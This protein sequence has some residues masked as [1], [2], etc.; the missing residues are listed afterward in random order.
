MKEIYDIYNKTGYLHHVYLIEGDSHIL[1]DK[2]AVFLNENL[3]FETKANPDFW[4]ENYD[5]LGINE[6]RKIKE[7]QSRKALI[8]DK[9]IFV[10]SFNTITIEAQNSLLKLF[11]EPTPNTHFFLITR[12]ASILLPTL[13][14]RIVIVRDTN[15]FRSMTPDLV[16]DFIVSKKGNRINLLKDII[17]EKDKH[18]AILFLDE[19]EKEIKYNL[20]IKNISLTNVFLLEEITKAKKYLGARSSSIKMILE[21]IALS[22]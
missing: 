7:V 14:S 13:K 4:N 22:I 2:I 21:N 8:K 16:K 15:K 20:D 9:K 10:L 5:S 11:E 19:L 1:F 17:K 12:S 18:S 3:G 6:T